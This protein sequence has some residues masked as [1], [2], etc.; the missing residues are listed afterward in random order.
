MALTP[1]QLAIFFATSNEMS[2]LIYMALK[3]YTIYGAEPTAYFCNKFLIWIVLEI[4]FLKWSI[5]Q[6]YI[7][8]CTNFVYVRIKKSKKPKKHRVYKLCI[9]TNTNFVYVYTNLTLTL[10]TCIQTLYTHTYTKFFFFDKLI[11]VENLFRN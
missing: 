5:C 10:Y 11:L 7:M 1:I 3:R 4:S 9:R 2:A 8:M 6:N